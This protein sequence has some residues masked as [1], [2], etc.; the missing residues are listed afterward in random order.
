MEISLISF[1]TILGM[2][3]ATYLTRI[4]GIWLMT[5]IRL[6]GRLKGWMNALPG[7]ILVAL[8]APS[9]FTTNIAD[10]GA[11]LVTLFIAV[12]TRNVLL[13]MLVGW[14]SVLGFRWLQGNF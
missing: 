1:L 3:V 2:G 5:Y 12:K 11:A 9:V 14:I 13:A 10:M 6:S 8:I 4:G 7:A